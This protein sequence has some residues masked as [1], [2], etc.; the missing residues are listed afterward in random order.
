MIRFCSKKLAVTL[1]LACTFAFGALR[2]NAAAEEDELTHFQLSNG[3][4]VFVKED[5]SR[6]VAALQMW[7]MVGSAYENDAERGISH[8]IEHMAFKG[9]TTRGVGKIAEE[10][11]EIGGEMNA[12]TSWDETVFHIVVPSP[13]VVR[14]LDILTD[15]V[16]RPSIDPTNSNEKRK[17]SLKKSWRG[18]TA[19]KM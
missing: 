9:T 11:E 19:R 12:Y 8:V 14:G 6:K 3:L 18:R 5:H 15:A 4:D 2:T 7:V 1:L 17:W 10:I 13:E 16:F